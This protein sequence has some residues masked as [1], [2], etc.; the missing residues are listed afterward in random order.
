MKQLIV[1][2][3][4]MSGLMGA[5]AE[6]A[7]DANQGE[8]I[9]SCRQESWRVYQPSSGGP[10]TPWIA[11]YETRT[12]LICDKQAFAQIQERA[13]SASRDRQKQ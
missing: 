9:K 13:S 5:S 1:T 11:R 7:D 3:C 6:A 4:L 2:G 10:R 8:P 12:V